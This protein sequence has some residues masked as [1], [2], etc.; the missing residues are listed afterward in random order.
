MVVFLY[1]QLLEP[2]WGTLEM[3][4]FFAV[5][6]LSVAAM[7][8]GTYLFIYLLTQDTDYLFD[9]YIHG[10]AGY[11]AGFAIAV[12]QAMPDHVLISSPFGKLRNLH[13]PL[14]LLVAAGLARLIGA[15]DPPFPVMF[16]W[17]LFISWV[18]LRFYQRHSN[19]SRGDMAD[20]FGL[21][22]FFPSRLSPFVT[23]IANVVHSL[24]VR[25]HVCRT[26]QRKYD[27][28]APTTITVT[29]PGASAQEVERRR[30]LAIKA[31]NDR[32]NSAPSSATWPNMV[33]GGADTGSEAG[34]DKS[35]PSPI[36]SV[37]SSTGPPSQPPPGNAAT[38]TS[39]NIS[40]S[41]TVADT[42]SSTG[43]KTS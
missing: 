41:T 18:Y 35:M 13:I 37:Q 11:L 42:H 30:L 33:D 9:N 17:G 16:L 27:V 36:G 5:V 24:L 34:S 31:L 3:I 40:S 20:N 29:L 14:L 8:T 39:I 6:N 26:P 15:V 25:L 43:A 10:M 38:A 22:S 21:A 12:K 19:G 32:L 2:L 4:I 1:G 28:G 7:T 23:I